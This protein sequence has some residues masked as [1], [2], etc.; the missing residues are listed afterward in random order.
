M[1]RNYGLANTSDEERSGTTATEAV[2]GDVFV[3]YPNSTSVGFEPN[4]V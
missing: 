2:A 4:D 3:R 1:L